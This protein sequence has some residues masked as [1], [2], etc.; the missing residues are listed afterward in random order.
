MILL[1]S[2]IF[3]IQNGFSQ[4]EESGEIVEW[5]MSGSTLHISGVTMPDYDTES[6]HYLP[7]PWRDSDAVNINE[8]EEVVIHEGVINIGKNAFPSSISNIK[9]IYLPNSL[10]DIGDYNFIGIKIRKLTIPDGV[11][12]IGKACFGACSDLDEIHLPNSLTYIGEFAFQECYKYLDCIE[13]PP[14]VTYIG[15][16]AFRACSNL[17]K[18]TVQTLVPVTLSANTFQLTNP[19]VVVPNHLRDFYENLPRWRDF[20]IEDLFEIHGDTLFSYNGSCHSIL[21]DLRNLIGEYNIRVIAAEA[22]L[23]NPDIVSA[24]LHKGL[25]TIGR[26]AFKGCYNLSR[27]DF[28]DNVLPEVTP[29]F[30]PPLRSAANDGLT[31]EE[32]AFEGCSALET[33][34]FPENLASLGA[35]AFKACSSLK[36][37]TLNDETPLAINENVFYGLNKSAITL[38]VPQGSG[39]RYAQSPVWK[40]F[41]IQERGSTAIVIADKQS[42]APAPVAYYNL[43]GQQLSKIPVRGVCIVKY[44]DGRARKIINNK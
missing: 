30:A 25:V 28:Y 7:A 8:I 16:F 31:I 37:I 35:Y 18:I 39:S 4:T 23:D 12:H 17:K 21:L 44:S 20:R 22:F 19:V 36:A 2:A 9:S 42:V 38:T 15:D 26:A 41:N 29:S 3:H 27:F 40:D 43:Q 6:Y 14:H 5:Y 11:T 13:I 10:I 1:L 33:F 32:S 34:V 24:T